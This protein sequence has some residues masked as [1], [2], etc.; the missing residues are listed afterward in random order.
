MKEGLSWDFLMSCAISS[1]F[2]G[3]R[4]HKNEHHKVRNKLK[5]HDEQ[6]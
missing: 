2:K 1:A 4:H 6:G 3:K 5:R